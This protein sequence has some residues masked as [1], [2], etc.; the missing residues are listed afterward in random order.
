MNTGA[1]LVTRASRR[2]QCG[3]CP[4]CGRRLPLTFH[5]L[6]PRKLHRRPRFRK[7]YS[8][9][10]LALGIYV[11]RDC[12]DGIHRTYTEMELARDKATPEALLGDTELGRHFSWLSRQRRRTD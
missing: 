2:P 9:A 8:R 12:H 4:C 1:P 10:E 7:R 11:C 3:D 5:H 6:I